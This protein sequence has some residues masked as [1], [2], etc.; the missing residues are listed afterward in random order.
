[1]DVDIVHF[2]LEK[3]KNYEVIWLK[4]EQQK[5]KESEPFTF[6]VSIN[7]VER[8]GQKKNC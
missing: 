3:I 6:F 7:P 1:M 8:V 5:S 4:M 2:L